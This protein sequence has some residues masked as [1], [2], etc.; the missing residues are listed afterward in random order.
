MILNQAQAE[1][2]YSAMRALNNVGAV[3]AH[4]DCGL[5][6]IGN[7]P[8]EVAE[9]ADGS[10]AVGYRLGGLSPIVLE[11]HSSKAAFAIAYGLQ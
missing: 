11:N 7:P 4:A 9:S 6:G 2:V 5:Y 3:V 10:V 1:A 8:L